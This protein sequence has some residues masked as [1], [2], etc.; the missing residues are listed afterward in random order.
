VSLVRG[1]AGDCLYLLLPTAWHIVN[2]SGAIAGTVTC[3]PGGQ[4]TTAGERGTRNGH[5]PGTAIAWQ[6]NR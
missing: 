5:I 1:I 3:P 2:C 4:K 6:R